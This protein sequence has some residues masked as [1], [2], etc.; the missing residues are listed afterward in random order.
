VGVT[1]A[2][3]VML[4]VSDGVEVNVIVGDT[5]AEGEGGKTL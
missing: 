4:G 2:V 1:V 3:M 5:V